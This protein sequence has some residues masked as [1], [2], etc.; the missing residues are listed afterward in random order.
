M[1]DNHGMKNLVLTINKLQENFKNLNV[2]M[3]I[4]LPQ[5]AVVGIQSSGKSSVLEKFI[6]RWV[7]FML[8]NLEI[9]LKKIFFFFV[10]LDFFGCYFGRRYDQWFYAVRLGIWKLKRKELHDL[11]IILHVHKDEFLGNF[12]KS[13]LI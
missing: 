2:H 4:D 13:V 12:F 8:N 6:G 3:D 11:N 7:R 1:S 9:G 10:K 5:I